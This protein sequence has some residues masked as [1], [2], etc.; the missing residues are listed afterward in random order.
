MISLILAH[1]TLTTILSSIFPLE[2]TEKQGKGINLPKIPCKEMLEL[3]FEP[4]SLSPGSMLM[5]YGT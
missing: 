2:E 1:L 4:H 3:T 5:V